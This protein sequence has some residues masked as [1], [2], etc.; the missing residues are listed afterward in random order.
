MKSTVLPF[1]EGGFYDSP[2]RLSL[3]G[4]YVQ[5]GR[6][7]FFQ[8]FHEDFWMQLFCC[9]MMS[10]WSINVNIWQADDLCLYLLYKK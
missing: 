7:L 8:A 6:S 5:I 9:A 10:L 2:T 1:Q 3:S 4:F